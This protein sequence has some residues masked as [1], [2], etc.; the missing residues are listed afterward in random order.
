MGRL[1]RLGN[2]ASRHRVVVD[3]APVRN[4]PD[5]SAPVVGSL[6]RGAVFQGDPVDAS[7]SFLKL[8]DQC[9][10]ISAYGS[11]REPFIETLNSRPFTTKT[12]MLNLPVAM[13]HSALLLALPVDG[14]P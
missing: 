2:G 4:R 13:Q 14:T 11:A 12:I 7:P 5:A 8:P 9:G 10:F 6:P 3:K 1:R